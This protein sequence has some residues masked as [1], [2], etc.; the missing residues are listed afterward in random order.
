[1]QNRSV[2]EHLVYERIQDDEWALEHLRYEACFSAH[3]KM[4]LSFLAGTYYD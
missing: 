1:M 2:N 3:Q 4:K